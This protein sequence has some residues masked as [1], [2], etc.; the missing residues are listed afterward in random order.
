M[1]P[2]RAIHAIWFPFGNPQN[3][4]MHAQHPDS[5]SVRFRT[6]LAGAKSV[7]NETWNDYPRAVFL[8]SSCFPSGNHQSEGLNLGVMSHFSFPELRPKPFARLAEG[9]RPAPGGQLDE[10]DADGSLTA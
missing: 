8:F 10:R 1:T 5:L 9:G 2:R 7:G 3:R 4:Y 6:Y